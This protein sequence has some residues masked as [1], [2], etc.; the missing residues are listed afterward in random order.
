MSVNLNQQQRNRPLDTFRGIFCAYASLQLSKTD[1]LKTTNTGSY[2]QM[3]KHTTG[4]NGSGVAVQPRRLVSRQ[5]KESQAFPSC[6]VGPHHGLLQEALAADIDELDQ[7]AV[8]GDAELLN[9]ALAVGLHQSLAAGLR[10]P[11]FCHT[12]LLWEAQV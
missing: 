7:E 1:P 4:R 6:P 5:Q 3:G 12:S 11:S 8:P 9:E 10:L 2:E